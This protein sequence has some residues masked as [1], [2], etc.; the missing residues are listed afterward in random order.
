MDYS[1]RY[2]ERSEGKK[3]IQCVGPRLISVWSYSIKD[4][5]LRILIDANNRK[6]LGF[7]KDIDA[8]KELWSEFTE[9]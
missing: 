6:L 8:V 3:Y 2:E 5:R 4:K 7:E 9:Q 1:L